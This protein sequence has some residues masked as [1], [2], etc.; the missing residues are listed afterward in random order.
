MSETNDHY[1][2]VDETLPLNVQLADLRAAFDEYTTKKGP[3]HM[4]TEA[5]KLQSGAA[6]KLASFFETAFCIAETATSVQTT[7]I[8]HI[9]DIIRTEVVPF[10]NTTPPPV[11]PPPHT[12]PLLRAPW[13]TVVSKGRKTA[14]SI[15]QQAQSGATM[16]SDYPVFIRP[17]QKPTV[18]TQVQADLKSFANPSTIGVSVPTLRQFPDGNLRVS[19][20]KPEEAETLLKKLAADRFFAGRY[21][22]T[23]PQKKNPR[24]AIYD[25]PAHTHVV[26]Q[27]DCAECE[28]FIDALYRRNAFLQTFC[29]DL[30]A[31]KSML[32]PK[33]HLKTKDPT[34]QHLVFEASPKLRK[35]LVDEK[36]VLLDSWTS[37]RVADYTIVTRCFNCN[38]LGHRKTGRKPDGSADICSRPQAC[39]QCSE[40]H[41]FNVCPN[42]KDK[43]KVC[44]PACKAENDR[45]GNTR[46]NVRHN[47]LSSSCPTFLQFITT[48]SH[49]TDYGL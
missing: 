24:I 3:G 46:L 27:P 39:S 12:Q 41:S 38:C 45:N 35:A 37:V 11:Q 20:K 18:I 9:T 42:K 4:R 29:P 15:L 36:R 26:G 31:F 30:V 16:A 7:V 22:V 43:A 10:L 44:C 19:F 49:K 40:P 34:V 32:K 8:S 48:E 21:N 2:T 17:K 23:V 47:A 5:D 28:P 1:H 33:L 6:A 14:A 13:N 25:V